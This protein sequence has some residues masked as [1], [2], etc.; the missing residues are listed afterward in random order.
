MIFRYIRSAITQAKKFDPSAPSRLTIFLTYPGIHA[1]I[2]YRISHFFYQIKWT[3][4]ARFIANIGRFFTQ[5]D[6]H[7]GA[8][9]AEGLFIDHGAGTVIGQTA[10]IDKNVILFHGVTLGSKSI[11][12]S[13]TRHPHLEE[14]VV[15]YPNS[16]ILGNI[17]IGAN[18]VIGA[19]S[20]VMHDIEKNSVVA[21]NPL[22][23]LQ[24][25]KFI[26]EGFEQDGVDTPCLP[27]H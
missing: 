19:H 24:G 10:I 15:I 27:P 8:K 20:L 7:P 26:Q 16:T 12:T 3:G 14:N 2:Y 9:I 4:F 25:N 17:T 11:H 23:Y 22:R 13:G 5:I 1:L 21:G 18:T 6:I